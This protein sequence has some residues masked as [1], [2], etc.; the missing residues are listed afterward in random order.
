MKPL[1]TLSFIVLA[2]WLAQACGSE[3]PRDFNRRVSSAGTL[4]DRTHRKNVK[5]NKYYNTRQYAK[6]QNDPIR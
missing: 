4:K 5:M 3:A 1:F 2:G 6:Y